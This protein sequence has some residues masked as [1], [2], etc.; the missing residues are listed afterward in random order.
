MQ[1]AGELSR[2]GRLSLRMKSWKES[3]FRPYFWRT[4]AGRNQS[5]FHIRRPALALLACSPQIKFQLPRRDGGTISCVALWAFYFFSATT[6]H[7]AKERKSRRSAT[8]RR[9]I[10]EKCEQQRQRE[11]IAGAWGRFVCLFRKFRGTSSLD[12]MSNLLFEK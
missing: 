2:A 9:L 7:S 3:V 11:N 6:E 5:R 10:G 8:D 1:P 4:L 12:V